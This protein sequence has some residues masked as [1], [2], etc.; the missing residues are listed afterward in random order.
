QDVAGIEIKSATE[1]R[2]RVVMSDGSRP[3]SPFFQIKSEYDAGNAGNAGA[4]QTI[5]REFAVEPDGSFTLGVVRGEQ[6]ISV[7]GLPVSYSV[8][9]IPYGST[10]LLSNPLS[11]NAPPTSEILVTLENT[12]V[13]T[14]DFRFVYQFGHDTL[15]Q[16]N[17]VDSLRGTFTR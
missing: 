8:K 9:S 7:L 6:R 2:G 17:A 16:P 14:P 4:M 15:R 5:Q 11:L 10:D 12:G 1:V 3:A 13:R